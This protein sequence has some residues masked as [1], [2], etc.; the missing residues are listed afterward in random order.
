MQ[1]NSVRPHHITRRPTDFQH[2]LVFCREKCLQYGNHA[3]EAVFCARQQ[4][5]A[6]KFYFVHLNSCFIYVWADAILHAYSHYLYLSNGPHPW[7]SFIT[8]KLQLFAY[9]WDYCNMFQL[10]I[11]VIF[12]ERWFKKDILTVC[13]SFVYITAPWK[14]L[15][16]IAETFNSMYVYIYIYI[17]IYSSSSSPS[18]SLRARCVPCS[19]ILK[20][21]LVPPSLLRS[22][23]V[24]SSF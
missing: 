22:S 17:Y 12:R 24:P 19:L 9:V 11:L 2:C 1:A 20:V 23:N 4:N 21:E 6:I 3:F 16:N 10:F 8:N 14:C 15:K 18:C 7:T 5:S 13:I